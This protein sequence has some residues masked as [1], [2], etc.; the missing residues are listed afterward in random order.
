MILGIDPGRTGAGAI[1]TESGQSVVWRCYWRPSRGKDGGYNVSM[2]SDTLE[3]THTWER[4]LCGVGQILVSQSAEVT[5][6]V[7]EGQHTTRAS[8]TQSILALARYAGQVSGPV[9]DLLGEDHVSYLTVRQWRPKVGIP[10]STRSQDAKRW[11]CDEVLK[12]YGLGVRA[13]VAEAIMLAR[14]GR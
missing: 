5:R 11:A 9:V 4:S 10:S 12:L 3:P 13:D 14:S 8:G 2:W 7:C 1:I 6:C